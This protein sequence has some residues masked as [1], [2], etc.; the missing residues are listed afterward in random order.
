[1]QNGGTTEPSGF[2][3]GHC[4][5]VDWARRADGTPSSARGARGSA[6]ARTPPTTCSWVPSCRFFTKQTS[7]WKPTAGLRPSSPNSRYTHTMMGT[8]LPLQHSS[9]EVPHVR[10]GTTTWLCFLLALN[11]RGQS[12]R[13]PSGHIMFQQG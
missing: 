12:S 8:K 13:K 1:M 3:S 9:S 7:H 2:G 11:S 10:G 5:H 4:G 6:T